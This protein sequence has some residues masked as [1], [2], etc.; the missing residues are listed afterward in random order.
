MDAIDR[1]LIN[2]VQGG[3][4]ITDR[5]YAEVA[6]RLG[7]D[8]DDVIARLARLLRE[9]V[10]SRFGPMYDA[11]RLGG[12]LTLA[13]MA[14]PEH[15]FDEVAAIVNGFLE[16]AHNY[17]RTHA[18]NMWFVLATE[19]P[20]RIREVIAEIAAATGLLVIDLPKLEEY[21]LEL[22]LSA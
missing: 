3:F 18:L 14:V 12:G 1:R 13:A 10:L 9:G 5:P 21:F 11:E 17:R 6:E 20:E 16:V 4:P 2:A 7:L 19:R 15:R 22:K 8:E